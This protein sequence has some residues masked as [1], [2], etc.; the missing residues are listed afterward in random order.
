MA[1]AR[2]LSVG[3]ILMLLAAFLL[4]AIPLVAVAWSAVNDVAAGQLERLVVA[5]PA[6]AAFAVLL[7]IFGRLLR[8]LD[9]GR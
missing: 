5:I 7:A 3:K 8:R 1:T 4:P 9:A 6:T 2:E